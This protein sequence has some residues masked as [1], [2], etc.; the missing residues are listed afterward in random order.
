MKE[1][2][3]AEYVEK[4]KA[5]IENGDT[6]S[7]HSEADDLLC[8]FLTKLGYKDLVEKYREVSKWYS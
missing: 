1:K 7:A 5:C 3:Q 4:M 2:L 8:E 6:E